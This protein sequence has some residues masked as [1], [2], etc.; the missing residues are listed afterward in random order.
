M[1]APNACGVWIDQSFERSSVR[2]TRPSASA[3]LI[4]SVT[5]AAAIAPAAPLSIAAIHARNSSADANGRAASCTTTMSASGAAASALRTDSER[6]TP[7]GTRSTRSDRPWL[8]GTPS[9]TA[10]TTRSQT[11]R[12]VSALHSHNCRPAQRMKALGTSAP[13]RSPAPAPARIPRTLT[14]RLLLAQAA[15]TGVRVAHDFGQVVLGL[16]LVH[17]ERVHHLGGQDL[18]GA[19]VHLLLARREALLELTDCEVADNLGELVDVAGLD[20]LAVELEPAVPVLRRCAS[21][22]RCAD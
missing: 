22:L 17:R 6:C 20:L 10:I 12:I 14:S 19:C 2:A 15:A 1:S 9:G 3:S 11:S 4:V 16:F 21:L 18:A 13:K 7:P 8:W 5:G